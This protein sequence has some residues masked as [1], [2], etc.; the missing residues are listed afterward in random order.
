MVLVPK[1]RYEKMLVDDKGYMFKIRHYETLLKNNGVILN[2]TSAKD[3]EDLTPR[4]KEVTNE[5]K[6]KVTHPDALEIPKNDDVKNNPMNTPTVPVVTEQSDSYNDL[7]NI[8]VDRTS[9]DNKQVHPSMDIITHFGRRYRFYAER[10]LRYI[11]KNGLDKVSWNAQRQLLYNGVV[12]PGTD[13]VLIVEYIF[14]GVGN[15]PKG[16]KQFRKA[17]NEINVPKVFLKTFLLKPPGIARK[18]KKNWITY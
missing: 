11:I 1:N 14:K 12:K 17:L 16:V 10:L 4:N 7:A 6:D 15:I 9:G 8:K 2:D 3:I 13:I 5:T 18:V